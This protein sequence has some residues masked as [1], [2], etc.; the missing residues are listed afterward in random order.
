[1]EDF[2]CKT[3]DKSSPSF[4][5]ADYEEE[6]LPMYNQSDSRDHSMNGGSPVDKLGNDVT[7]VAEDEDDEMDGSRLLHSHLGSPKPNADMSEKKVHWTTRDVQLLLKCVE[8]HLEDF[9][10][11]KKHKAVWQAI[12]AKMEPYGFTTEHCYNKWKNLRRDVRLLVNNPSKVVRNSQILREV[13]RLILIIY[14][15]V[16]ASTMQVCD[17]SGIKSLPPTPG[18]QGVNYKQEMS[19][20]GFNSPHGK[21]LA[22]R[23]N[24]S[25]YSSN[26]ANSIHSTPTSV[27]KSFCGITKS[28]NIPA[29]ALFVD[30]RP[31]GSSNGNDKLQSLL[32]N[33]GSHPEPDSTAPF[34]LPSPN[35]LILQSQFLQNLLN[36]QQQAPIKSE[37]QEQAQDLSASQNGSPDPLSLI[38]QALAFPPSGDPNLSLLT[39]N[40]LSSLANLT[41]SHNLNEPETPP[42]TNGSTNNGNPLSGVN[43]NN[44]NNN[45]INS[46]FS[47]QVLGLLPALPP[48]LLECFSPNLREINEIIDTL[49]AED[50]T[51]ARLAKMASDVAT[52]LHR[53]HQ[54]RQVAMEKL[55]NIFKKQDNGLV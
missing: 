11:Q 48:N 14:P 55:L 2:P 5:D 41:P 30:S 1:M 16:N 26:V 54:N 21:A 6:Q 4:P 51:Q 10:V 24:R 22:V 42:M 44:S 29:S 49:R 35:S 50:V 32:N 39:A 9:N 15:N 37:S 53:S 47:N 36:Q 45:P 18:G 25:L 28:G 3:S 52:E 23:A 7:M 43:D 13:A 12:G 33:Q 27:G 31:N 40:L 8:D 17:R 20:S 34:Q 19:Y 38:Q 46:L